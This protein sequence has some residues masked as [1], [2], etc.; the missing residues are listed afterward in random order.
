VNFVAPNMV[1]FLLGMSS[2]RW[3]KGMGI[4]SP[5]QNVAVAASGGRLSGQSM[6][7]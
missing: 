1:F 2:L 3:K 4:Y 7:G 6:G 5:S